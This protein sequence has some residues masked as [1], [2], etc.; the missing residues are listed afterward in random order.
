MTIG[1]Y[2][3]GTDIDTYHKLLKLRG[4]RTGKSTREIQLGDSPEN[5][6]KANAYK[7]INRRIRQVK[8]CN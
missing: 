2:L 3:R 7:R 5:L 4:G 6:M 1:E 8:W